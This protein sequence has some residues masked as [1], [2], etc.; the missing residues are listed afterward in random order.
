MGHLISISSMIVNLS[1]KSPT[2]EELV[3]GNEKWIQY[4]QGIFKSTRE[5]ENMSLAFVP[6]GSA[7]MS[8]S[9][10]NNEE[11]SENNDS[12][13]IKFH[14]G[15][16]NDFPDFNNDNGQLDDDYDDEYDEHDGFFIF[17][18]N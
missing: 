6:S 1:T 12:I 11:E 17:L 5:K 18:K 3:N 14:K 10:R 9:K 7:S 2:I 8:S 13:S 4:V 15:F 16:T